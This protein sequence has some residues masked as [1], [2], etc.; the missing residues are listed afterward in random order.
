MTWVAGTVANTK[1]PTASSIPLRPSN[2]EYRPGKI[3]GAPYGRH[4]LEKLQGCI[5]GRENLQIAKSPRD[6]EVHYSTLC[7]FSLTPFLYSHYFPLV[8][9]FA[10][11]VQHR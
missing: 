6:W 5:E 1:I 11:I 2:N 9:F 8:V 3:F 10:F 4:L 7:F